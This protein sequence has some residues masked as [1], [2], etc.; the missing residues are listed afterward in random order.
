MGW[1]RRK[2]PK[3]THLLTTYL[4]RHTCRNH[5]KKVKAK[6]KKRVKKEKKN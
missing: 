6:E 4:R 1:G 3:P 2:N 5:Y